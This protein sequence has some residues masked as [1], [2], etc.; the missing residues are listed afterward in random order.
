VARVDPLL[1]SLLSQG[2]TDLHIAANAPP[3][4]RV[5]GDLANAG[6]RAMT[7][8]DVE[9][10]L[11]ELVTPPQLAELSDKHEIV[12]AHNHNG[13]RFRVRYGTI[14]HGLEAT[15]R[16]ISPRV[17]TLSE[18]GL[19][20]VTWRLSDRRSGL[21]IIAGPAGSGRS[22]TLAAMLDQVNR[23]RGCHVLTLE[24]PVEQVFE[25]NRALF[26]QREIRKDAPDLALAIRAAAR[27]D[28]D[29]C[30]I[31]ALPTAD[32]IRAMVEL[33]ATEMAVFACM[34]GGSVVSTLERIFASFSEAELPRARN[35]LADALAGVVVQRLVPTQDGRRVLAH[36]ALVATPQAT[37]A[38]REGKTERIPP[39]MQAGQGQG[40][41]T[42]DMALERLMSGGKIAPEAALATAFDKE[43]FSK[44]LARHRP[45]LVEPQVL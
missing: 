27:D 16:L 45:D 38:I 42:L 36:E 22:T 39:L 12:F 8:R 37:M 43:A 18:L 32:A 25:S 17:A 13:S 44:I 3:M 7:S 4:V 11:A 34:N 29:V 26:T 5:R 23:T 19:P 9:E 30:A 2:G 35:L 1:D 15:F 28:V 14:M 41:Q 31:T 40:M 21:T 20:E 24:D 6:D 33:A 10:L